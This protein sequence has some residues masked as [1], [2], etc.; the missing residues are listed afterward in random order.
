MQLTFTFAATLISSILFVNAAPNLVFDLLSKASDG[1]ELDFDAT[2]KNASSTVTDSSVASVCEY[3]DRTQAAAAVGSTQ[4][5]PV[6]LCQ[7]SA[8]NMTDIQ[9]FGKMMSP[10]FDAIGQT[11]VLISPKGPAAVTQV[12]STISKGPTCLA[13]CLTNSTEKFTEASLGPTCTSFMN[14]GMM[15]DMKNVTSSPVVTCALS[16]CTGDEL[17]VVSGLLTNQNFTTDIATACTYALVK[18][19]S[20]NGTSTSASPSVA[21]SSSAAASS[22]TTT[23]SKTSGAATAI[24]AISFVMVL[25][26]VGGSIHSPELIPSHFCRNEHRQQLESVLQIPTH[27]LLYIRSITIKLQYYPE[28]AISPQTT[29][30]SSPMA[31]QIELDEGDL[32]NMFPRILEDAWKEFISRCDLIAKI[33]KRIHTSS[34]RLEALSYEIDADI[35]SP[36]ILNSREFYYALNRITSSFSVKKESSSPTS[37]ADLKSVSLKLT[38]RSQI[39][40]PLYLSPFITSHASQIRHMYLEDA[41]MW[42]DAQLTELISGIKPLETLVIR[43]A[44][45]L[46]EKFFSELALTQSKTLRTLKLGT[47]RRMDDI[48]FFN[49]FIPA[50]QKLEVLEVAGSLR[51][52][53]RNMAEYAQ[54][55]SI[56]TLTELNVSQCIGLPKEFFHALTKAVPLLRVLNAQETSLG[57]EEFEKLLICSTNHIVELHLARCANL[58]IKIWEILQALPRCRLKLLDVAGCQKAMEGP[59][60]PMQ[61]YLAMTRSSNLEKLSVGPLLMSKPGFAGWCVLAN[62]ELIVAVKNGKLTGCDPS[63]QCARYVNIPVHR[64]LQAMKELVASGARWHRGLVAASGLHCGIA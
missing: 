39:G 32:T 55:K 16:K 18:A 1:H 6:V 29:S 52:W 42:V 64:T 47:I 9:A 22:S 41:E 13:N 10:V 34:K 61:A 15:A 51:T 57:D 63:Q 48:A 7:M 12:V 46:S 25:I 30:E 27:L 3:L 8:C 60:A 11:C 56:Q 2:S 59:S 17:G 38:E 20:T 40:H 45:G 49:E 4:P 50:T 53:S 44:M 33:V 21:K 35:A 14:A 24:S 43:K 31:N 23:A 54:F 36:S 37:P 28:I 58:S 62:V 5:D 26:P 19:A